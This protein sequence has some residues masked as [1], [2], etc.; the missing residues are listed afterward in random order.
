MKKSNWCV[1][2]QQ[3]Q[4]QQ[5]KINSIESS[6]EYV[7]LSPYIVLLYL[8]YHAVF[9]ICS[10]FSHQKESIIKAVQKQIVRIVILFSLYLHCLSF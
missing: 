1:Q 10:V 4:K 6:T 3:A 2:Q 7:T 8:L 9:Q 5:I